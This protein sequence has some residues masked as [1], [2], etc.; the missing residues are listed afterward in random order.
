VV[1]PVANA[2]VVVAL[3]AAQVAVVD[4]APVAAVIVT[5]VVVAVTAPIR[6]NPL[7]RNWLKS[8]F[9]SIAFQR[10]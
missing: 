2:V 1:L 4:V 3:A 10:P 8:W 7:A 5:V 6:W 9:T